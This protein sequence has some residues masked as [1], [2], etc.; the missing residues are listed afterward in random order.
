MKTDREKMFIGTNFKN[1]FT[2]Y[3]TTTYPNLFSFGLLSV[4]SK[5]F[6]ADFEHGPVCWK[7]IAQKLLLF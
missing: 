3:I 4:I 6:L 1:R 5:A 2:S 7:S